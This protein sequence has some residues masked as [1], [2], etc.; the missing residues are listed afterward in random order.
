MAL[1]FDITSKCNRKCDYCMRGTEYPSQSVEKPLT[2]DEIIE[3]IGNNTRIPTK[4]KRIQDTFWTYP[5]ALKT[6]DLSGGE[7]LI[8]ED[9]REGVY[10]IADFCNE[11][12]INV[13]LYTNGLTFCDNPELLD[14][15]Y[16]HLNTIQIGVHDYSKLDSIFEL[17]DRKKRIDGRLVLNYIVNN[18]TQEYIPEMKRHLEEFGPENLAK[19]NIQI[20]FAD[21]VPLGDSIPVA[22]TDD[23]TV[24]DDLDVYIENFP[25]KDIQRN[26]IT[27]A[28]DKNIFSKPSYCKIQNQM[29]TV[30]NYGYVR[31]CPGSYGPV[32]GNLKHDNMREIIQRKKKFTDMMQVYD[33]YSIPYKKAKELA[34]VNGVDYDEF[35][36][37]FCARLLCDLFDEYKI[38]EDLNRM[39]SD[40]EDMIPDTNPPCEDYSD[41]NLELW[42]RR[43]AQ[44]VKDSDLSSILKVRD[45]SHILAEKLPDQVVESIKKDKFYEILRNNPD[46]I[47]TGIMRKIQK[48]LNV[49]ERHKARSIIAGATSDGLVDK[50]QKYIT[51]YLDE[52]SEKSLFFH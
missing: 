43:A 30:D 46:E 7:P 33:A 42:E 12:N 1:R 26:I 2:Y 41:Y 32:F 5:E 17:M 27:V 45:I 9:T 35:S 36:R 14:E 31:F 18:E 52:I 50:W 39:V 29:V 19:S 3:I 34:Q 37:V 6:V 38:P 24:M 51:L 15:V 22:L 44:M 16:A 25:S 20:K 4:V 47:D 48:S 10:K 28:R 49:R 11:K 8:D 13:I 23:S 21:M 40:F